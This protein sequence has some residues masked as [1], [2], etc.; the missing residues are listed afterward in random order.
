MIN[1]D[2]LKN[3]TWNKTNDRFCE[4]VQNIITLSIDTSYEENNQ[5]QF[6]SKMEAFTFSIENGDKEEIFKGET[7]EDMELFVDELIESAKLGE[8]NNS[9]DDP[10]MRSFAASNVKKQQVI[11]IYDHDLVFDFQNLRNIY[12]DDFSKKEHV[13]TRAKRKPMYAYLTREKAKVIFIDSSLLRPTTL[14]EWKTDD[15]IASL[16]DG[17]K[18]YRKKYM[19]IENIPLTQAGEIRRECASSVPKDWSNL[20]Q[21]VTKSL[22]FSTFKDL[23]QIFMGGSIG[24]SSLYMNS[25]T[26][27]V[28]SKDLSSAYPFVL[29]TKK[30]PVTPFVECKDDE[31]KENYA[32]YYT[33]KF[34]NIRCKG[35]NPFIEDKKAISPVN[36][37]YDNNKLSRAEYVTVK[38]TDVDLS[39][40]KDV[41]SYEYMEIV[42]MKRSELHYLPKELVL[43]I[44]KY[45]N[46]KTKLKN[47]NQP[48]K[49]KRAKVYNN[50]FYG[51]FVTR[52]ITDQVQFNHG[53]EKELLTSENY[54]QLRDEEAKKK[55]L[56]TMYQVGPWVTAYCRR[57]LWD[58]IIEID[59]DV[60]YYD[61]DCVKYV[62]NHEQ[63]F[64]KINLNNYMEI[65]K[66]S[67]ILEIEESL[68]YPNNKMIGF[69]ETE[70]TA[71]EFKT[72]GSKIYAA[73]YKGEIKTTI[74]G[75]SKEDGKNKIHDVDE[76]REGLKW[77]TDETS[78]KT[79][80]FLDN[81]TNEKEK[82][83]YVKQPA[84]FQLNRK[85][86]IGFI[87]SILTGG[88][89]NPYFEQTELF[90]A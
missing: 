74:A 55:N 37:V 13:F 76:L 79:I 71:D 15:N 8:L 73:N 59:D 10:I 54:M 26:K 30:Y 62:N 45:Y 70:K 32:Y 5:G 81:M 7:Y 48:G 85:E 35:F 69:F 47:T 68:Y 33:V 88:C 44:L 83:G 89:P 12:E 39:I 9:E 51:V 84:T 29:T 72:I 23:C 11:R 77:E 28:K 82:F 19:R 86:N 17:I 42:S 22:D 24:A 43:L 49:Y 56:F 75:L 63:T 31:D 21:L 27:K 66:A 16:I 40:I 46:E 14:T 25:V 34:K 52:T 80:F 78:R 53:W 57:I 2:A 64:N 65:K 3:I 90:C 58:A 20:C 6:R 41:Y 67:Q 4:H 18:A 87:L 36:P 61:T 38:V 50:C 1:Y 60:V